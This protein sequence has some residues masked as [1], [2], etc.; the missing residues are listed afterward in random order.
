MIRKTVEQTNTRTNTIRLSISSFDV[1]IIMLSLNL[2]TRRLKLVLDFWKQIKK[3]LFHLKEV[4]YTINL[5]WETLHVEDT[6]GIRIPDYSGITMVKVGCWLFGIQAM[7]WILYLKKLWFITF[8]VRYFY[9]SL[10]Q[11]KHHLNTGHKKSW[12]RTIPG[13]WPWYLDLHCISQARAST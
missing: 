3:K 7:I 1:Q 10:N 9:C 8:L 6:V 13:F 5:R 4:Q 12:L 11:T 2:E